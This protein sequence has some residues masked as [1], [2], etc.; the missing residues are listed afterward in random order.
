[1]RWWWQRKSGVWFS[2]EMQLRINDN[3]NIGQTINVYHTKIYFSLLWKGPQSIFQIPIMCM[4]FFYKH[5]F[6]HHKYITLWKK[7]NKIT[8][9]CFSLINLLIWEHLNTSSFE[10]YKL[11]FLFPCSKKTNSYF[12]FQITLIVEAH[13]KW[14]HYLV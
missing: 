5:C 6:K 8:L 9:E 2:T 13:K 3:N 1:M 12:F 7:T 10:H 14:F 4:D 11:L